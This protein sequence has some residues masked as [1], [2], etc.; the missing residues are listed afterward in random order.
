MDGLRWNLPRVTNTWAFTGGDRFSFWRGSEETKVNIIA[1]K[2][3][4]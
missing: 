1:N 3:H 4:E 2:P